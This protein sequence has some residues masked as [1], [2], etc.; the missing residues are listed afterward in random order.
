[1][2]QPPSTARCGIDPKK[3][4]PAVTEIA[5]WAVL[6]PNV[7]VSVA[8]WLAVTVPVLTE[9]VALL[10]LA[11][12]VTLLGTE[13]S[14]LLLLRAITVAFAAA[15]F[16]DNVHRLDEFPPSVEGAQESDA[17]CA[18]ATRPRV[19]VSKTPPLLAVSTAV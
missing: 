1:M 18:E 4:R 15:W 19:R 11:G 2:F 16:S 6:V 17:G 13:T 5:V 10:W 7:A 9:K 3:F 14:P 8:I 12:T